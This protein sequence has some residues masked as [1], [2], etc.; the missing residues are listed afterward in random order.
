MLGC[1]LRTIPILIVGHEKTRDTPRQQCGNGSLVCGSNV[2]DK[3]AWPMLQLKPAWT[4]KSCFRD[5][6]VGVFE[7]HLAKQP[8]NVCLPEVAGGRK[9]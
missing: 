4:C 7:G 8:R 1:L 9:R 3:H 5:G 2:R 6:L